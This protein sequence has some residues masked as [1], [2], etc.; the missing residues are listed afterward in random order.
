MSSE[1]MSHAE[2][3]SFRRLAVFGIALSTAATL[4]AIIAVPMLYNYMQGVQ[5]SLQDD[6]S[7]CVHRTE[8]LW[9][10]YERYEAAKGHEGRLKREA[11]HRHAGRSTHRRHRA[12]GAASYS[13][14]GYGDAG[15]GG[16]S[17]SQGGGSCCSCGV[18]EAGPA[19]QPG[20]DGRPGN[21]GQPAGPP[22]QP[23]Q[24]GNGQP[25]PQG[26]PGDNGRPG[27]PGLAGAPGQPGPDGDEGNGG[28][29]DHCPPPRTAPGY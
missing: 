18:G 25:G 11:V 10:E 7:F 3:E 19:G 5:S 15:V 27:Q 1:K 29:C 16:G 22:G 4:T 28:G 23:G 6:V 8:G 9:H 14:G 13:S 20:P 12:R 17:M 26:P 2:A 21:D 24:S